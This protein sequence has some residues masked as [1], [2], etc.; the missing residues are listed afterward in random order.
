VTRTFEEIEKLRASGPT[1]QELNDAVEA[2]VR[3]YETSMEQNAYLAAQLRFRY[4]E[5]E[6]VDGL[7]RV[8][9]G[10]RALTREQ[11]HDAAKQYLTTD[12]YVKVQ[13]F[14]EKK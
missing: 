4:R 11:I 12:R 3:S 7:F 6:P 9:E 13:L 2:M 1:E 10:Y 5:N 14:P 8:V